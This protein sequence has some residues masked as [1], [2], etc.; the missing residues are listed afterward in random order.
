MARS[1][2]KVRPRT[3]KRLIRVVPNLLNEREEA[4]A[5]S[6]SV[7]A[8]SLK[9][10]LQSRGD[11]N[12]FYERETA[13]SARNGSTQAAME[14]LTEFAAAVDRY[15]E[16]TWTGSIP[17]QYLRYIADAFSKIGRPEDASRAL[18]IK[19]SNPGRRKGASTHD[20]EAL[21]A[22]YW[23]LRRQGYKAERATG[24]LSKSTGADRRTIQ[25]AS[26]A[27]GNEAYGN[28]DKVDEETLKVV[29]KKYAA[30]IAGI[31]AADRK[32]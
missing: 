28:P 21:A 16:R 24:E 22:A 14:I 25:R 11:I 6:T 8:P 17:W 32:R 31:L 2:P 20:E 4:R 27:N 5:S 26:R 13:R 3:A 12:R 30:D 15:S 23:C 10:S 7:E 18:G 29:Y 19:N 1:K 9:K